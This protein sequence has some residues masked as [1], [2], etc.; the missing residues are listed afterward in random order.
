MILYKDYSD[1]AKEIEETQPFDIPADRFV[2]GQ[3]EVYEFLDSIKMGKKC[4]NYYSYYGG[5]TTPGCNQLVHFIIAEKPLKI[6]LNQ[7][8]I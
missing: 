4:F 3:F 7:V 6:N 1:K 8:I 2:P 5:L